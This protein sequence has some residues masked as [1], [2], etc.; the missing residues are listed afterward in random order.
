M[1]AL[2]RA[3]VHLSRRALA[4]RGAA[5]LLRQNARDEALPFADPLHLDSDRLD[6]LIELAEPLGDVPWAAGTTVA[7]RLQMRREYAIEI[8]R[9]A[10]NMK[11]PPSTK[12][13]SGGPSRR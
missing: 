9:I 1:R 12:N 3:D 4:Q 7:P 6:R 11:I 8:G 10:T 5:A 2:A 13:S